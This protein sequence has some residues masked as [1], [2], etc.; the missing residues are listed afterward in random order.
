MRAFVTGATGFVGSRVAAL[1]RARG[2]EV[3]ALVRS[4]SRADAITRQGCRVVEGDLSS[5]D[6]LAAGLEGCDVAFHLAAV[7]RVGV[8]APECS[9]MYEVNVLGTQR[10][11]EAAIEARVPRIV[12]VSTVG[13]F[14]NT[15]GVVVDERFTRTN[16]DFLSCYDETKYLAHRHAG[17]LMAKGAPIVIAQPGGVYGPGDHSQ[18]GAQLEGA[19]RGRLRCKVFADLGF[20]FV[21]VDDAAAG[22]VLAADR[23]RTGEAYVIGGEISTLGH[24]VEVACDAAGRRPPRVTI[25][26]ALVR[27]AVPLGPLV[28]G[29]LGLGPNLREVVRTCDGVT[30]WAS[31]DKARRELGHSPRGLA[32]GVRAALA[33]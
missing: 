8:S 5:K 24:L 23:G 13:V 15:R 7:Y 12:H 29:A 20:T 26:T 30:F 21:H 18:V 4:P 16:L 28:G 22:I 10:V 27:L 11:L 2:D 1:L 33:A 32:A 9:R 3:V 31:D 14:G 25:P 17:R 19:A 6:A